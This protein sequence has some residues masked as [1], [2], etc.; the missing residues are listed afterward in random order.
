[1]PHQDYDASQ[2]AFEIIGYRNDDGLLTKSSA[3]SLRPLEWSNRN[4]M[5]RNG[6]TVAMVKEIFC[7]LMMTPQGLGDCEEVPLEK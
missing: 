3:T 6:G 1:M 7:G 2:M 4:V 5:K